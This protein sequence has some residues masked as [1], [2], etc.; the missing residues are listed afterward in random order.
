MAQNRNPNQ[1]PQKPRQ[2]RLEIPSKLDAT[3]ANAVLIS[4]THSEII[5]DFAQFLP[6]TPQARV[7]SRII[8]T[9]ANAKSFLQALQTNLQ[10]FEAKHGEIELPPKP[11]SLADQL[12]RGIKSDDDTDTDED[13]EDE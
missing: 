1:P 11:Q 8:M 5:M 2:V 13:N 7:Q 12:F 3:Y 9:P 6:N 4:Q 10:N